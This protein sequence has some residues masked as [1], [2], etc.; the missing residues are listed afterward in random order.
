MSARQVRHDSS[1]EGPLPAEPSL[2]PEEPSLIP[3][4][5][6]VVRLEPL[7]PAI[8]PSLLTA[9]ELPKP[10]PSPRLKPGRDFT[11]LPGDMAAL[12]ATQPAPAPS[13]RPTGRAGLGVALAAVLVGFG[14]GMALAWLVGLI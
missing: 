11:P 10:P 14:G 13:W 7:P 12:E 2:S 3:S 9:P 1:D 8:N 6:S 4:A 5:R